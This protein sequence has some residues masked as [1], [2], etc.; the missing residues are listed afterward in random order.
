MKTAVLLISVSGFCLYGIS[1]AQNTT[2]LS[3]PLLNPNPLFNPI[4]LDGNT[5]QSVALENQPLNPATG[6]Y[7]PIQP[8]GPNQT[9]PEQ[10][11]AN[12]LLP[13]G[14]KNVVEEAATKVWRL[15]LTFGAGVFYDDNIFISHTNRLSDTVFTL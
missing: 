2:S 5:N 6:T 8:L 12:E 13:S 15:L 10:A 11:P 4:T 1:E 14:K 7:Q 9:L 3:N